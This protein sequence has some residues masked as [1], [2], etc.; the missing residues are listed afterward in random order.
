MNM[1]QR[2]RKE[3][4]V[5]GSLGACHSHKSSDQALSRAGSSASTD[6]HPSLTD[7]RAPDA[8]TVYKSAKYEVR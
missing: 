7:R 3:S 4:R 6:I 2:R 5:E 8:P 1:C